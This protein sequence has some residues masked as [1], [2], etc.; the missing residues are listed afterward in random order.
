MRYLKVTQSKMSSVTFTKNVTPENRK[1]G[2]WLLGYYWR[3][4]KISKAPLYPIAT[5]WKGMIDFLDKNYPTYIESLGELTKTI[6]SNILIQAMQDTAARGLTDYP[7][8][9]YF[10]NALMKL[11]GSVS[12]TGVFADTASEIGNDLVMGSRIVLALVVIGGLVIGYL[13][14][15]PF[16]PKGK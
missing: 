10:N 12:I 1:A 13:Y 5:N 11:T 15:K 16:L 4:S 14:L 9:S 6:D 2:E 8:P 3:A 7:R